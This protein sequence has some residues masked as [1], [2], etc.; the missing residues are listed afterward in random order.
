MAIRKKYR[1]ILKKGEVEDMLNK[2]LKEC[3]SLFKEM[4][5]VMKEH[6][7][8]LER[9]TEANE[10]AEDTLLNVLL[11]IRQNDYLQAWY[12]KQ[13]NHAEMKVVGHHPA[14]AFA[15]KK[16]SKIKGEKHVN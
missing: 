8:F 14:G 1:S 5:R 2:N 9:I 7:E 6:R 12:P 11:A 10:A 4:S 15:T 3:L 16:E 13:G